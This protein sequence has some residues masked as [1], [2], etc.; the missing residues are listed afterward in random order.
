MVAGLIVSSERRVCETETRKGISGIA[1]NV[2]ITL[3]V[4]GFHSDW[5]VAREDVFRHRH[6][7]EGQERVQFTNVVLAATVPA[8][9]PANRIGVGTRKCIR[10]V[11]VLIEEIGRELV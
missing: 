6:R 7:E 1:Y 11:G 10:E 9:Q 8:I 2:F 4:V 5:K 3:F